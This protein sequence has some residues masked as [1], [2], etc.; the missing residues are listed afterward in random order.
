MIKLTLASAQARVTIVAAAFAC[1]G[2]LGGC[3][4]IDNAFD[5]NTVCNRYRDCVD[6][7]YDTAACR[8]RCDARGNGSADGRSAVNRCEACLNGMSC[9][10]SAFQCSVQCASIV[11]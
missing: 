2:L 5:C 9:V 7:A 3:G 1:A 11:P 6:S 10:G 8:T 4:A